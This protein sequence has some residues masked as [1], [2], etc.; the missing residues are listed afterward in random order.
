MK[1]YLK[2]ILQKLFNFFFF[3]LLL[4]TSPTNKTYFLQPFGKQV[5]DCNI[6]ITKSGELGPREKVEVEL[7]FTTKTQVYITVISLQ[8]R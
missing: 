4:K 2:K 3:L 1:I 7:T 5:E 6:E 8:V